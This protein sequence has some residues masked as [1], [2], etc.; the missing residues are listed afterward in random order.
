MW[1]DGIKQAGS[2]S[3]LVSDAKG[4]FKCKDEG[5]RKPDRLWRRRGTARERLKYDAADSYPRSGSCW[6]DHRWTDWRTSWWSAC[7]Q[8]AFFC[9]LCK[10]DPRCSDTESNLTPKE[11]ISV[12][13]G[14]EVGGSEAK[15]MCTETYGILRTC[16][17]FSQG[18]KLIS[19]GCIGWG[20][21]SWLEPKGSDHSS[22][23]LPGNS[24]LLSCTS[25][26]LS[27]LYL[28]FM[29]RPSWC[30]S[31][32]C[33]T[34]VGFWETEAAPCGFLPDS[35]FSFKTSN[36]KISFLDHWEH[37]WCSW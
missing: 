10:W 7:D 24:S 27:Q 17:P 34:L 13:M 20:W 25:P 8:G 28:S 4:K 23:L 9:F 35:I 2:C 36:R 22:G 3:P 14:S 21:Q 18:P 29:L 37:S 16:Y 31:W 12:M 11:G 32:L 1:A 5:V 6:L 26:F 33:V 15:A 30:G 19:D